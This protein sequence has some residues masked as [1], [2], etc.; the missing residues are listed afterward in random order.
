MARIV[1]PSLCAARSGDLLK[2]SLVER[3]G[4]RDDAVPAEAGG[5]ARTVTPS[6]A[7]LWS[8]R[9]HAFSGVC[10]RL[11]CA[12]LALG[13]RIA[14]RVAAERF[15]ASK[16]VCCCSCPSTLAIVVLLGFGRLRPGAF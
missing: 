3:R 5:G 11:R 12:R 13:G 10:R 16:S 8:S 1:A 7:S 15:T 14:Q 9:P 4:E 6:R 2:G